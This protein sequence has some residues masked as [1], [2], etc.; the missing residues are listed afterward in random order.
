MLHIPNHP[1]G[2]APTRREWLQLGRCT[3]DVPRRGEQRAL[4]Q[5][6][7]TRPP[8]FVQHRDLAVGDESIGRQREQRN[9]GERA[10]QRLAHQSRSVRAGDRQKSILRP[11]AALGGGPPKPRDASLPGQGPFESAATVRG[12]SHERDPRGR[13][14]P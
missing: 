2:G 4:L 8:G 1:L 6:L 11:S 14:K 5:P 7:E 10:D 9:Q 3:L 12:V 13:W